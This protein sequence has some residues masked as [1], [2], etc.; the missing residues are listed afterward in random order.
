MGTGGRLSY[1]GYKGVKKGV[2]AL[3]DAGDASKGAKG[4]RG[5]EDAAGGGRGAKA[6]SACR[7]SFVPGTTVLMADG[8][9]KAIEDVRVGD[10]VL[11]TDPRT[12]ESGP[13]RVTRLITS[14]GT[15]RLVKLTV[16]G[17]AT[18]STANHPYYLV[19][20]HR[21][22]KASEL[23]PGDRLRRSDGTVAIVERA[24]RFTV[25]AQRVHN[26]TVEGDHT[27]YAGATPVLVHNAG[28]CNVVSRI[29]DDPRLTREAARAGRNEQVQ[30]DFDRLTHQLQQGNMNPG[31]GTRS[32]SGGV[33]EARARSGAR[34]YFRNAAGA[35]EIVAKSSKANQGMVISRLADLYGR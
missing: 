19:D 14:A 31:I 32:L 7:S 26:M 12:G 1:K 2:N 24:Q 15:K 4:A 10:L 3:D 9:R 18:I 34:V 23:R 5:S 11:A 21:W 30:A 20:E 6:G 27:Y 22:A 17:R 35:A 33:F 25:V 16:A 13:H 28:A 29:G 8:S